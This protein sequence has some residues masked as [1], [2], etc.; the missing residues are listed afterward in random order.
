MRRR[1]SPTQAPGTEPPGRAH[2][3]RAR[4]AT[5]RR[6]VLDRAAHDQTLT[7]T[8][9]QVLVA[10]SWYSDDTGKPCWPSEARL[11]TQLGLSERT[12]S[13]C[14]VQLETAGYLG[15]LRSPPERDRETGKFCRRHTNRYLL[16]KPPG[17]PG[18]WRADQRRVYR[19]K[20]LRA[21]QETFG[22]SGRRQTSCSDQPD[23]G[24]GS[25]PPGG[26]HNPAPATPD[27][28]NSGD[29]AQAPVLTSPDPL[30]TPPN[31]C[32]NEDA[33]HGGGTG[34]GSVEGDAV[35]VEVRPGDFAALRARLPDLAGARR[36]HPRRVLTPPSGRGKGAVEDPGALVSR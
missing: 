26:S 31:A 20:D 24:D 23:T 34:E 35:L 22:G 29:S 21:L 14:V 27:M 5:K 12:V 6:E 18:P 30:T 11:A 4:W 33:P 25:T 7:A 36:E 16:R 9:H 2:R 17:P 28:S 15:V 1:H 10:L 19:S 8:D 3:R 13:R 32:Q